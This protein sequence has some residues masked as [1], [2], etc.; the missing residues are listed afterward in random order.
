MKLSGART[1]TVTTTFTTIM[2]AST[3]LVTNIS[4]KN[5]YNKFSDS[6]SHNNSSISDNISS[7]NS[8][9][10][11]ISDNIS[12]NNNSSGNISSE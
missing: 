6:I 8:Y 12:Y 4:S 3:E 1:T 5:Y 9:N 10:N 2:I 7:K 11:N